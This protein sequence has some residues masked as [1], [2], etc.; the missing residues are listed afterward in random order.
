M[1]DYNGADM[2]TQISM[3][4][5]MEVLKWFADRYCGRNS[6]SGPHWSAV[7][8]IP[9]MYDEIVRLTDENKRQRD[10]LFYWQSRAGNDEIIIREA[11]KLINEGAPGMAENILS[12]HMEDDLK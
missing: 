10:E 2:D 8:R 12:L 5:R 6:R 3:D 4:V 7:I 11:I 1:N 9:F